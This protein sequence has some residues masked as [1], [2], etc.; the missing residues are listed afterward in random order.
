MAASLGIQMYR[1]GT[2]LSS[3]LP[4]FR[5]CALWC[6]LSEKRTRSGNLGSSSAQARATSGRPQSFVMKT[7]HRIRLRSLQPPSPWC[8]GGL[9]PLAPE[10]AVESTSRLRRRRG[11]KFLL[12]GLVWTAQKRSEGNQ[13]RVRL[14]QLDW[15]V[16][17]GRRWIVYFQWISRWSCSRSDS[18]QIEN[19]CEGRPW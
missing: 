18:R 16:C 1:H 9:R 19:A 6:S 11:S 5:L 3:Y 15:W 2:P 14:R 4:P 13:W 7:S 10:G 17:E 8:W 12:W